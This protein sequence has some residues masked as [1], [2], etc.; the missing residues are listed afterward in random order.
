MAPSG[1]GKT[2]LFR[3]IAG[4][5]TQDSG[6]II[7]PENDRVSV[8]FQEDRLL[9]SLTAFENIN[10]VAKDKNLTLDWLN[11]VGLK[12][13]EDS[14]PSQLSGGMKRRVSLAR[15]MVFTSGIILL[16]E[17]F[18]GLDVESSKEMQRLV[19]TYCK[20]KIA[21]MVTHSTQE[22]E[23]SSNFIFKGEGP[24]LKITEIITVK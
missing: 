23:D 4:L 20:D 6:S 13:F 15:A 24:P 3:L 1:S 5:D 16:D 10:I 9:P 14:L 2:T 12:G 17:P 8:M 18:K 19:S 22:A 11:K 7:Y 21:I